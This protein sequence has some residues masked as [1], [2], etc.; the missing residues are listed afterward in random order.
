MRVERLA[1]AAR[2]HSKLHV[3]LPTGAKHSHMEIDA[4]FADV[5]HTCFN[6]EEDAAHGIAIPAHSARTHAVRLGCG[7][8]SPSPHNLRTQRLV[9]SVRVGS[10]TNKNVFF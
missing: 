5:I 4:L 1:V 6:A 3:R 7:S 2:V 10:G 8:S 9:C